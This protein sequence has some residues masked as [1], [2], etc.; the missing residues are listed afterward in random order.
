VRGEHGQERVREAV[1]TRSTVGNHAGIHLHRKRG[2]MGGTGSK[3]GATIWGDRGEWSVVRPRRRK[4]SEQVEERWDR[5]PEDQRQV[6]G[7]R[8]LGSL[9]LG[10]GQIQRL[11]T[12]FQR[13]NNIIPIRT[14]S[15]IISAATIIIIMVVIVPEIQFSSG[16]T[17][18]RLDK[19]V[20]F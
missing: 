3:Q 16:M 17:L 9:G 15:T 10:L 1:P 5:L 18:Q 13:C 11:S 19:V 6:Q 8:G 4:A 12:C 20:H 14:A 2:T 7:S